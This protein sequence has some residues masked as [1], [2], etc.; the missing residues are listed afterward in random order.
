M[1]WLWGFE[2]DSVVRLIFCFVV[3]CWVRGFVNICFLGWGLLG[4]EGVIF[5]FEIG[6]VMVFLGVDFFFFVGVWFLFKG[7]VL[8]L[9]R[10]DVFL[11]F[12]SSNVIGV[13]IVILF[14][15][16][17]IRMC[18]SVFLLMVLIFIVVL[19]VLILVIMLLVFMLLFFLISYFVNV[20]F[21]IVGDRVGMRMGIGIIWFFD[22]L[23]VL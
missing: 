6:V 3:S 5:V 15:L 19:L 14:V 11:F 22:N 23:C 18:V 13:L 7:F 9:L 1:M 4:V 2:L 8:N 21:F 12:F 16:F 20:F 10:V 17:W